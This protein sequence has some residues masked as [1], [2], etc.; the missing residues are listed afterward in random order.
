ML[1][2]AW[3]RRAPARQLLL[4]LPVKVRVL[5]LRPE[6]VQVLPRGVHHHALALGRLVEGDRRA[7]RHH[8]EAALEGHE[9]DEPVGDRSRS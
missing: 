8:L 5:A 9:V 1:E 6:H 4:Q 7:Q 3:R 2:P